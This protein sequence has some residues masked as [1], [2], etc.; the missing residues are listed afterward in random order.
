[1]SFYQALQALKQDPTRAD[2]AVRIINELPA[3]GSIHELFVDYIPSNLYSH[4]DVLAALHANKIMHEVYDVFP[5]NIKD[6]P[7]II[8]SCV[9]EN[10]TFLKRLPEE[11][12]ERSCY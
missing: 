2:M 3:M 8:L 6:D 12:Q 4:P 5:Q 7:G 1:M 10:W 9:H 11:A